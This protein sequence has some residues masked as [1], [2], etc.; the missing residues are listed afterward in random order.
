MKNQEK[1]NLRQLIIFEN[2]RRASELRDVMAQWQAPRIVQAEDPEEWSRINEGLKS[3]LQ[4]QIDYTNNFLSEHGIEVLSD[5][6]IQE[7]K[8]GNFG[9]LE[10]ENLKISSQ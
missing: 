2:R 5:S 9:L 4:A 10:P 1:Q 6:E 3:D 7:L 8:T